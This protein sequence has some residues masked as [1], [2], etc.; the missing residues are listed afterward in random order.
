LFYDGRVVGLAGQLGIGRLQ[1][2]ALEKADAGREARLLD[3]IS[4]NRYVQTFLKF[5]LKVARAG[6]QN[7]DLLI[8]FISHSITLQLSHSGTPIKS[9]FYGHNINSA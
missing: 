5:Y 7:Q 4:I 9:R 3:S 8:T 6:E 1:S 2:L